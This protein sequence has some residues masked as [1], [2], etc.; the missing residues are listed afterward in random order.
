MFKK[1]QNCQ[2]NTWNV[3]KNIENELLNW[4]ASFF[5]CSLVF[6]TSMNKYLKPNDSTITNV[7]CIKYETA[8]FIINTQNPTLQTMCWIV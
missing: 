4:L 5:I 2:K 6:L 7:F 8:E 1:G 3:L